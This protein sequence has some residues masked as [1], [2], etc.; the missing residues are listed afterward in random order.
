M[1]KKT[2]YQFYIKEYGQ[3]PEDAMPVNF[4]G[5][6]GDGERITEEAAE[7]F[8]WRYD[9]WEARWPLVF[10]ILGIGDF[11]VNMESVPSF[12]AKEQTK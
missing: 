7:E 11:E 5:A 2:T 4:I 3:S 8:F 10:T 12:S 1:N 9:G 6:R